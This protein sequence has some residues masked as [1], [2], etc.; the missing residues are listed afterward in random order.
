MT[1]AS[2]SEVRETLEKQLTEQGWTVK[3]RTVEKGQYSFNATKD[4]RQIMGAITDE[5]DPNIKKLLG[6][7][8][9]TQLNY[10]LPKKSLTGSG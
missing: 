6:V 5:V 8:G 4:N 2:H 7:D 3:V 9:R 10:I 1:D